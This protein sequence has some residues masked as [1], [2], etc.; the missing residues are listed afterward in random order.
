[1]HHLF[2]FLGILAKSPDWSWYR[3]GDRS[4]MEF[5]TKPWLMPTWFT[6]TLNEESK[7]NSSS[8]FLLSISQVESHSHKSYPLHMEAFITHKTQEGWRGN[9]QDFHSCMAK[10]AKAHSSHAFALT[11]D[12]PSPFI[13]V[14]FFLFNSWSYFFVLFISLDVGDLEDI[15]SSRTHK[16]A[17]GHFNLGHSF[18]HAVG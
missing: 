10:L 2:S 7:S 4:G 14:S 16:V 11:T 13:F 5:P 1:M 12:E 6:I 18:A 15:K 8:I 3:K 17:F 9:E